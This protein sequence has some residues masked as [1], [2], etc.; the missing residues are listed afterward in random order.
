MNTHG[1][2]KIT[3]EAY[4]RLQ[5]LLRSCGGV[6]YGAG[7]GTMIPKFLMSYRISMGAE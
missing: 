4:P 2:S 7:H 6:K 5:K 3:G 1:W